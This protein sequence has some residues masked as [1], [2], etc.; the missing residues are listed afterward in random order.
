MRRREFSKSLLGLLPVASA[1]AAP[2][3]P[4]VE[5]NDVHS[6]LNAT[7]VAGIEP[8]TSLAALRDVIRTARSERLAVC[9]AGG[10]DAMGGQQFAAG[11]VLIDTSRMNR[12]LGFDRGRGWIE[13]ESGIEW[14]E[15]IGYLTKN[16]PGESRPWG[17]R[18]KQ[19]GA[20]RLSMGGA[21][22]ANIHGRGLRLGPFVADVES[23]TLVDAAGKTRVCSRSRNSELFRL[24]AGGYGLFGPVYSLTLR[25]SRRQTLQRV[26]EIINIEELIQK[27]EARVAGGYLF[28]DFQYAIDPESKD[29]LSRGVFSCYRPADPATRPPEK[30][31]ELS[32]DDWLRLLYLGHTSKSEAFRRY[33]EYYLSTSGQ[34][35]WSDT[36]Q[37]SFYPDGYH[38]ALDA[39][40]PGGAKASEMITEI[41]VPRSALVSFMKQAAEDFRKNHVEVIYGTVRFIE[42]DGE[43]FLAWA[44]QPYACV[45]FNLHV[46]HTP[47]GKEHSAAAFR[48]L[49]DMAI[50]R[51]GSYYLTY[52]RH[53]T[54]AQVEACYPQFTQFLRFK[55]KYDPEERF[56]SEWY[57]HYR[58]MFADAL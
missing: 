12:V 24:I 58:T 45:I 38:R 13:V 16:Q 54:R 46:V 32:D 37:M 52:H 43:S 28:G 39:K 8:V 49:I 9:I 26:V 7:T 47:E 55:K 30:Q 53:A 31:K 10:R 20:D 27:V 33:S 44:K 40:T 29:F 56:Q 19:T 36:H 17:I 14:P 21:L 50:L 42:R 4:A 25:L 6:Q 22:A 5:V 41:Y 2:A 15:L 3:R 11:G 48:R 18:Q 1:G 34:F 23:L 57:R 51:G 35:Y